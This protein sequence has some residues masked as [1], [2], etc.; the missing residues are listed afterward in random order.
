M[1]Y[2]ALYLL[3]VN[4]LSLMMIRTD[5]IRAIRRKWRIPERRFIF[6]AVIGGSIG[7]YAGCR[8]FRHKI[9]HPRFM[10]GVPIIL[11]VQL[12]AAGCILFLYHGRQ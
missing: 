3:L 4:I 6:L 8:L 9:N 10:V 7:I 11:A 5:K 1:P 12:L 2:A